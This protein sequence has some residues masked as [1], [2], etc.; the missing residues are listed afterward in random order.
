[1]R[2]RMIWGLA[3]LII[4]IIGVSVFLLTRTTETEPE[5][6]YNPLT[7]AEK[8]QVDRS[9]QDAIDKEK[10]NLP[11]IAEGDK[12]Q[13]DDPI[14][15]V[16]DETNEQT[17]KTETQPQPTETPLENATAKDVL[18]S[19]FGY[20]PYPDVPNDYREAKGNP[21]WEHQKW[22]DGIALPEGAE[23]LHRVLIRVWKEGNRDWV[24]ASHENGKVRINYPN[25]LY[26]WYGTPYE[27]EDGTI[28]RPIRR[29]KG[30]PNARLTP[31]QMRRG[32][33]PS[34]VRILD[35]ETEAIDVSEYLN[36]PTE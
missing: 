29:S 16:S 24:G 27:D 10:K 33:I 34:G 22:P 14:T 21:I 25:T 6:V 2:N 20:G 4:L 28:I 5:E 35:G 12:Q 8:E 13:V 36:L 30:D 18:V 3:I 19:P 32:I 26:I 11:P 7:P 23:L 1:M 9:I 15:E 17:S 31:D